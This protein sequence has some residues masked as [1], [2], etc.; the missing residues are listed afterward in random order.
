MD[1]HEFQAKEILAK[2][3]IATP[4]L[5]IVTTLS[6]AKTY[7][8]REQLKQAVVKVQVHAGGRGKAGGVRIAHDPEQILHNVEQMLGMRICNNQTT[9]EGVIAEKLLITPLVDYKKEYYVA[10]VINREKKCG[11]IILSAEGGMEI[12]QIAETMPEKI[13]T[14]PIGLNGHMRSYHLLAACKFMGWSGKLAE[15]GKKLIIALAQAFVDSDASLIEINPLV[16]TAH[17]TN[18]ATGDLI[19]LDAKLSIDDNAL[20]RHSDLACYFDPSQL[21]HNEVLAKKA[22]LAYISLDGDIGCMVNGAGLAMATMDLIHHWGGK[23]ANFLDVGGSAS[24]EKVS[25][26]FGIILADSKVKAILINIFGGIMNCVTLAAGIIA[27][28]G[29]LK[30]KVPLIIRM[31]GTNVAEGKKMLEDSQMAFIIADN[32]SD[33]ARKVVTAAKGA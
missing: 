9:K 31:E 15:K 4:P 19:A 33:A 26:G 16:E 18:G 25:E 5:A 1:L 2:Y 10:A 17:S 21:P 3:G 6:Q 28:V 14:I 13:L 11:T 30:I 23:A 32:L 24:K 27:A 22:D 7:I 12:E 20:F 29:E 8:E